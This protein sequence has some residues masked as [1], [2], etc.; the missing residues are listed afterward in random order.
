M[1]RI[2]F[3][4][5]A[6]PKLQVACRLVAKIVQQGLRVFVYSPDEN[7]ARTFDKLLR[8][9]QAAGFVTG[10]TGHHAP[11]SETPVVIASEDVEIM[12]H[13]VMINLHPDSPPSFSRFE[14][15]VELVGLGDDDRQLARSRFRFYRDRGYEI[16][17]Y[18]L[19][20]A[21]I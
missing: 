4:S 15:L 18:D 11:S 5:N 21:S 1:T 12:H 6:E 13:E 14:R 3:Y 7:T 9:Y 10:C 8:T 16:N 20:K 2:D 19:S 17:H